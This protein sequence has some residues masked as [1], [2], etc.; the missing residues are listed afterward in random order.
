MP[1]LEAQIEGENVAQDTADAC[2]A[3]RQVLAGQ[4][5]L[6]KCHRQD[7]F[8]RVVEKGQHAAAPAHK[9]H[10][11]GGAQVAAALGHVHSAE[12]GDVVGHVGAAQQITQ[13]NQKNVHNR[14]LLFI[15]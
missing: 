2:H 7:G 10:R 14:P 1:P 12:L 6:G 15:W 5:P 3:L 11:I 8:A 9:N 13:Q 4:Q